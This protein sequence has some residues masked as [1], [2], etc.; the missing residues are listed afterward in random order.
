MSAG[1]A[2]RRFAAVR[3]KLIN[4]RDASFGPCTYYCT[5]THCLRGIETACRANIFIPAAFNIREYEFYEKIQNGD[6]NWVVPQKLLAFSTPNQFRVA[7][8]GVS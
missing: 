4:F 2:V 3:P 5:L 7:P 8:N 1:E 6:L